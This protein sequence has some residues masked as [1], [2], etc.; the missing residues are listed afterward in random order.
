MLVTPNRGNKPLRQLEG[1]KKNWENKKIETF[2]ESGYKN[3]EL[4]SARW[5]DD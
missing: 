1:T 5:A 2:D 3:L 4:Q